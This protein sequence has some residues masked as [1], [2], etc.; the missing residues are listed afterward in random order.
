MGSMGTRCVAVLLGCV[1]S[2]GTRCVAVLL[3]GG[4][5][6]GTRGVGLWGCYWGVGGAC[7]PGVGCYCPAG[8][9]ST[10]GKIAKE[11]E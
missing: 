7:K 3:G 8:V 9:M 11:Y 6:M 10:P 1:G 5:S 4:G 2:M